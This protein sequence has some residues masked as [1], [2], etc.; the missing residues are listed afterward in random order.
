VNFDSV[1]ARKIAVGP[2]IN[3]ADSVISR[4]NDAHRPVDATAYRI[5][6]VHDT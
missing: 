2:P 4:L 6:P 3:D 1:V 5:T